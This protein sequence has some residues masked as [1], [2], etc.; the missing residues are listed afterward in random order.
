[1]AFELSQETLFDAAKWAYDKAT[2]EIPGLGSA[3]ALGV[4]FPDT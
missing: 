1:M 2:G 3:Q 4:G